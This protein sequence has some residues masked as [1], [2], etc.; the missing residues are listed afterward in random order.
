MQHEKTNFI[1]KHNSTTEKN[2]GD[3]LI[4]EHNGYKVVNQYLEVLTLQK[5]IELKI[6]YIVENGN[7]QIITI[8][9]YIR[10]GKL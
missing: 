7:T 9:Q 4:L 10:K 6:H 1:E 3:H 8:Q 5:Q 2:Q